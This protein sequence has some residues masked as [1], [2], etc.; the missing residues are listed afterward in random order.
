MTSYDQPP[1]IGDTVT[2]KSPG[3]L[4]LASTPVNGNYYQE[5]DNVCI[6]TGVGKVLKDHRTTIDYDEWAEQDKTNGLEDFCGLGR[7]EY[8]SLLVECDCGTGWA[9]RGAVEVIK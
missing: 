5:R 2:P 6:F 1:G 4:W 3:G 8:V 7:V 9:G